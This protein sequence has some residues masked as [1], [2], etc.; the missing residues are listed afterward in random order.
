M[1]ELDEA[2]STNK[3]MIWDLDQSWIESKVRDFSTRTNCF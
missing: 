2:H 3:W 1:F